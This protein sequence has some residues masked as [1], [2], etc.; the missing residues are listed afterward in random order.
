MAVDDLDAEDT[1]ECDEEWEDS[2]DN[3]TF[4]DNMI[5]MSLKCKDDEDWVPYRLQWLMKKRK[6]KKCTYVLT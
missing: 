5:R 3:R 6:Y 4:C 1:E 2:L